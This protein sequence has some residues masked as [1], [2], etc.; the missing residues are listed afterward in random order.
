MTGEFW[1]RWSRPY[2]SSVVRQTPKK[3]T[4][5]YFVWIGQSDVTK[6]VNNSRA[7]LAEKG[8]CCVF[9]DTDSIAR[10]L[11]PIAVLFFLCDSPF[12]DVVCSM[13][14]ADDNEV[15]VDFALGVLL[16]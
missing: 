3:R 8:Q 12:F 13:T 10:K 1:V 7:L 16:I 6:K 11:R 4:A 5:V 9:I 14:V 2:A 15:F